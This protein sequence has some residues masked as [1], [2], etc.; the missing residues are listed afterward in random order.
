MYHPKD[1]KQKLANVMPGF[2]VS[3]DGKL[4]LKFVIPYVR[5][6][7]LQGTT[8][9]F[10][11]IVPTHVPLQRSRAYKVARSLGAKIVENVSPDST[12][13]SFHYQYYA[14]YRAKVLIEKSPCGVLT[15]QARK[16]FI[17]VYPSKVR[18]FFHFASH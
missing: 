4:N 6:K 12:I 1:D 16:R 14:I 10:S 8:L 3:E 2:P 11:G 15:S 17:Q 7:V 13:V 18:K 9:A 5:R